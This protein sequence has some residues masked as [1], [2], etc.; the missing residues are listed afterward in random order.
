MKAIT[1][2]GD[3]VSDVIGELLMTAVAF[4]AFGIIAVFVLSFQGTTMPHV[5]ID[6]WVDV[7]DDSVYLRHSGGNT[8]DTSYIRIILNLN[9]TRKE[10]SPDD[11]Y[12]ILGSS[13]W[14][15]GDTIVI[16]TSQLWS[17]TISEDDYVDDT[18]IHTGH[19]IVMVSGVLLGEVIEMTATPTATPTPTP[20][21]SGETF[22]PASVY[23]TSGGEATVGQV[24]T[25][26][27]SLYTTYKIPKQSTYDETAYQQFN[28]T[29]GL[30]TSLTRV[31]VRINHTEANANADNVKIKVWEQDASVWHDETIIKITTWTL[32]EV[33]VSSYI[34]TQ[35]DINNLKVRY[36]AHTNAANKNS[37]IEY[38]AVYVE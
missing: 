6:G 35:N 14:G 17:I 7:N 11:V 37:N 19:N 15:L 36:L 27:D 23:D 9:G 33:D 10:L 21:P 12:A 1:E 2:N 3:A 30:T 32:D 4:L 38:V 8:V 20:T 22:T 25:D 16:N 13:T 31:L 5:D 24:Q 29:P 18:I 28:F 26:G 34:D